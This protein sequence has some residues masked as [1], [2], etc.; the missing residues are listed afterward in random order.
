MLPDELAA[1]LERA[2]D[3]TDDPRHGALMRRAAEMIRDMDD[4]G[5]VYPW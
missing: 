4:F 1:E 5:G 2:S 3:L